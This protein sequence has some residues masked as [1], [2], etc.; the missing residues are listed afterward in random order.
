MMSDVPLLNRRQ[1]LT[2]GLGSVISA[3]AGCSRYE[4]ETSET[5]IRMAVPDV[6]PRLDP[7]FATDAFSTRV[8]RLVYPA[9]IDFDEASLPTPW[10]ANHWQ[11]LD[12]L[13]LLVRLREGVVFHHGKPLGDDDVVATYQSILDSRTASPLKG[14]LRNLAS[15]SLAG[16]GGVIFHWHKPDQLSLFRLTVPIMPADLLAK[17]HDFDENPVGCGACRV[18]SHTDQ[19]LVLQRQDLTQL[20][21]LGVKDASVRLLKLVRGEVDLLQNDL[22]PELIHHARTR[23]GLRVQSRAGSSFSYIGFNFQDALLKQLP[24]RQAFAHAIDRAT[25]TRTLMDGLA[26]PCVGLFPPE[27]W[28]G[29]P[30]STEGWAYHPEKARQLLHEAGVK[31]G[32]SFTFK[33]STDSTRVRLATVYQQMLADVGIQLRVESH[34]WGTFYSDIKQ[35]RFQLY[36]LAW[37]GVKSPEI[38]DYAFAS[39]SIPPTGANRGHYRDVTLD[40]LLQ[41]ALVEPTMVDMAARYREVQRHLLA[42]LPVMP[43]WHDHQVLVARSEVR[44]YVMT[45]DGR[46]DALLHVRKV[47]T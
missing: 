7:R 44:D 41:R 33:T 11:W 38:F 4:P 43:L 32:T 9:L 35:G 39:H 22:S 19:K 6:T 25:I 28:C 3:F 5:V 26:T 47:L 30:S 31:L 20:V 27:H 13:R 37:V 1:C 21:F 16:Q 14:P 12:D 17:G 18:L 15:V 8:G 40:A 34:D 45:M 29:L 24:V 23:S 46:Y 2:L 36:G 10:L 42:Q